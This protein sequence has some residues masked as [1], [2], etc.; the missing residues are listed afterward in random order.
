MREKTLREPVPLQARPR[1]RAAGEQG[2]GRDVKCGRAQTAFHV[3]EAGSLQ[4]SSPPLFSL[5]CHCHI[6]YLQRPLDPVPPL[7]LHKEF[8]ESRDAG[9]SLVLFIQPYHSIVGPQK[10]LMREWE[11]VLSTSSCVPCSASCPEP[12]PVPSPLVNSHSYCKS[13]L[14]NRFCNIRWMSP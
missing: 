12:L 2:G 11:L 1:E 13:L 8:L 3:S 5:F 9:I 14:H 7:S 4:A 6:I 10:M